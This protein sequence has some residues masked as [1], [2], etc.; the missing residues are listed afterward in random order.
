MRWTRTL[1]PTLKEAPAEAEA[2]S[3]VLMLRAGLIRKLGSGA[4]SYLPLGWRVLNKI[5]AIVREEMD[6]TGALEVLMPA[7]WPIEVLAESGR[8]AVFGEDVL[9]ITDRHGR[10]CVLGP[11]HEEIVTGLVRDNLKSYRQL[12]VNIYQIQT[13]FRDEVR[14]RFGALR[15][16]EFLMKDAYSFHTGQASLERTYE[17]MYGAYCRIFDRCG[18]DYVV[19]EAESGAMGGTRSQEFMVPSGLGDDLYVQCPGCGYAANVDRAEIALPHGGAAPAAPP[20]GSP[21]LREV[22]TP[23]ATTIEKVSSF[24]GVTPDRLIK[25][26][27]YLADGAPVAALVRGDHELNESKLA[28]VL[29][30]PGVTLADAA[31]IE[32]A[33]RAPVG[34]AGP[35][36]LEG[37][38]IVADPA[39]MQV[40]DGVTGA[41]RKDA[42]L[43]GVVPGRDFQPGRVADPCGR[44]G[45]PFR[46]S[47]GIE[48]GHLFQ[49]G[50]KYS[51]ALRAT[52]LDARGEQRPYL[53]G[54]Y[55]IGINRIAA[56]RIE[57][58]SD[59]D[60]IIWSPD[61]AP[62][63]VLVLPLDMSEERLVA[64]AEAAYAAL[65][66][67]GLDALLDDRDERPGVKFNDADL[68]GFPLR[69]VVG[70]GYLKTGKLELQVR[71]DGSRAEV[72]PAELP[73]R[74][75]EALGRLRKAVPGAG[76]A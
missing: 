64:A 12:P 8:L 35:V 53:M 76:R 6:R 56:A 43:M 73:A 48:V 5:A 4:Y 68:I 59:E 69:V 29:G 27:L 10:E 47:H 67:D 58:S 30:A 70:K 44:C 40:T 62:Y 28:R 15:T 49:L 14:P 17:E 61:I 20:A 39:V 52:F 45:K 57:S 51:Q 1:I 63:E 16:R 25:T 23:A 75:R 32:S 31:T 41:N 55:G 54:C 50:T 66:A 9:R 72:Q 60:G 22:L 65:R 7:L 21:A 13:K 11:T 34:F 74:V 46:L 26:L 2:R 37:V 3:H 42:H 33:T 71:R 38:P 36:Q 18:L 19:I 24:L